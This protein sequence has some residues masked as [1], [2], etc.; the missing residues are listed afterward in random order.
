MLSEVFFN[1]NS[2]HTNTTRTLNTYNGLG[3]LTLTEVYRNGKL[4]SYKKYTYNKRGD[5]TRIAGGV[6]GEGEK[7]LEETVYD[8]KGRPVEV[9]TNPSSRKVT[10]YT[11]GKNGKLTYEKRYIGNKL[12]LTIKNTYYSNGKL[13]TK[14]T[15]Y[16][17]IGYTN[18]ENYTYDKYGNLTSI[19]YKDTQLTD[20]KQIENYSGYVIFY[21]P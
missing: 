8:S 19:E 4:Q 6:A 9:I 10:K 2:D 16:G 15:G 13:K 5:C 7:V 14:A 20:Y 11:Y 17:D 3:Y 1:Y 21:T 12:V 18:Y